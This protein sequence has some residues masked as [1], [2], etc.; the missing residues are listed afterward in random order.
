M[1]D[2]VV[3]LR[4]LP[5]RLPGMKGLPGVLVVGGVA[6]AIVVA[7]QIV[8][9][10]ADGHLLLA[11][12][13]MWVIVFTLLAVF[14]DGIHGWTGALRQRLDASIKAAARRAEDRRTW[15]I[16]QTDPRLMADLHCAFARAEQQAIDAGTQPPH[17]PF[18][19]LPAQRPSAFPTSW[20]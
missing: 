2:A 10:W 11:W 1:T 17:W 12:V 7:D 9:A 5:A 15:A 14:S 4:A 18:L 6:A 19:D 20:A 13:A 3:A 16:A 8:S